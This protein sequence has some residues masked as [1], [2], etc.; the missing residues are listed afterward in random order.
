MFSYIQKSASVLNHRVLTSCGGVS[1]VYLL[2]FRQLSLKFV[3]WLRLL[4]YRFITGVFL[5]GKFAFKKL[6]TKQSKY[7]C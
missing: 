3:M 2:G 5:N 4:Y 6:M 1:E 7:V